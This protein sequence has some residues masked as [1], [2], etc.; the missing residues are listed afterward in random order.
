MSA[1]KSLLVAAVIGISAIG[2]ADAREIFTLKLAQ[3]VAA[4]TRV[5]ALNAIWNCNGD[6][7]TASVDHASTVRSCRQFIR[8]AGDVRVVAYGPQ[9]SQLSSDEIARC[10]GETATQQAQTSQPATN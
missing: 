4:P 5:I 3:P 7:C 2:V 8:Q 9:G 6:T 10:N 1:L